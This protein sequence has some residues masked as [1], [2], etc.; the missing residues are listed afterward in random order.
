MNRQARK[1]RKD[2]FFFLHEL[3]ALRGKN[4]EMYKNWRSSAFICGFKIFSYCM[5]L[6]IQPS[7]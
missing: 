4:L 6:S 5:R 7:E 3:R 1:E 2:S